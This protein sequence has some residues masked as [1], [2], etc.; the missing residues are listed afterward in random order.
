MPATELL[1]AFIAFLG[2]PG[3]L[4]LAAL[5]I[6]RSMDPENEPLYRPQ[7]WG[8]QDVDGRKK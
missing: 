5:I 2:V 8:S 7:D 4:L 3:V 1:I 6:G